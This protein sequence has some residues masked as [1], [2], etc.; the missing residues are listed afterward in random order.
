VFEVMMKK[1]EILRETAYNGGRLKPGDKV[2]VEEILANAWINTRRA[3]LIEKETTARSAAEGDGRKGKK[4]E[5]E[6][7]EF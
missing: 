5:S 4:A 1:V 7:G 3:R 6:S 2:E